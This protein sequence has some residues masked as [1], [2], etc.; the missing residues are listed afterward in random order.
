MTGISTRFSAAIVAVMAMGVFGLGC[1]DSGVNDN[2]NGNNNQNEPPESEFTIFDSETGLVQDWITD[3]LIDYTR[4]G[5]WLSTMRGISFHNSL[6]DTWLSYG[7][8]SNLPSLEVT[9]IYI[10][11]LTG[12]IWAGTASGVAYLSGNDWIITGADSLGNRYVTSVFGYGGEIWVGT[13]AGVSIRAADGW[14]QLVDTLGLLNSG[15]TAFA[16]GNTGLWVGTPDGIAV[17]D[18]IEWSY[19]GST[20]LPSTVVR[21]LFRSHDGH[22]WVG[23]AAGIAMYNGLSWKWY[24]TAEGLPAAGINGFTE[25]RDHVIWVATDSNSAYLEGDRFV[26]F[27]LPDAVSGAVVTSIEADMLTDDLWFG[28]PFGAVRYRLLQ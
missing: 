15:V 6:Q 25:T 20:E 28:T 14:H 1:S 24:T 23:T 10:D 18:G 9:S 26:P 22:M 17:F 16:A 2:G 27:A 13:R 19:Y 11:N 8:E 4:G 7:P 21:S 3:I 12:D 5:L